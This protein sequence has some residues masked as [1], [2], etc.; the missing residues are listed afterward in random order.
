MRKNDFGARVL[1]LLL[2]LG[3]LALWRLYVHES[4]RTENERLRRA[5]MSG[6]W[7][8]AVTRPRAQGSAS[9]P[10][11]PLNVEPAGYEWHGPDADTISKLCAG[12]SSRK[13]YLQELSYPKGKWRMNFDA[14]AGWTWAQ[15]RW[16]DHA[17]WGIANVAGHG[18]TD[19]EYSYLLSLHSPKDDQVVSNGIL[20]WL[21]G[22]QG[23]YPSVTEVHALCTAPGLSGEGRMDQEGSLVDCRKGKVAIEVGSALGMVSF[24]LAARGMRVVAMDPVLPNVERMR[25]SACLN[26]VRTCMA[27]RRRRPAADGKGTEGAAG[28]VEH[29]RGIEKGGRRSEDGSGGAKEARSGGVEGRGR[30]YTR[31][32]DLAGECREEAHWG[33]FARGDLTV[34]HAAAADTSASNVMSA[35]LFPNPLVGLRPLCFPHSL[36]R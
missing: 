6:T 29:G 16:A 15:E 34:L 2:L 9:Q 12:E 13:L 24:Y 11:L 17:H 31:G 10:A 30:G 25:E 3:V 28:G 27:D 14:A 7:Q 36:L 1:L 8:Q 22:P 23:T 20:N 21:H 35:L 26:G 4:Q 5:H 32:E 19:K 33:P 18:E